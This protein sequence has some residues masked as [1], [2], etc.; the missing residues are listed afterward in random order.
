MEP[1]KDLITNIGIIA[2]ILGSMTAIW[3]KVQ[4]RFVKK[5]VFKV[6]LDGISKDIKEQR[7]ETK[8]Q[9]T[10]I[11]EQGKTIAGMDSKLDIIVANSEKRRKGD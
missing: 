6:H 5:D 9:W 4:A 10:E 3:W 1:D 11:T 2:T 7:E 8:E